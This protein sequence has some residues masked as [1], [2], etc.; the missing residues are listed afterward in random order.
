MRAALNHKASKGT[1]STRRRCRGLLA[2]LSGRE[3]RF[4]RHTN[5]CIAKT[6]VERAA[7]THAALA[8]ED[9]TGIRERT[10]QQRRLK[11]ERRR[12]NHW[13]FFQLRQFVT[14]KAALA[15]V[16]VYLVPAAYTSQMCH[17]CLYL[18]SRKGKR[19]TCTNHA[20]GWTGDADFNAAKNIRILGLNLVSQPRGPWVHCHL[21][22]S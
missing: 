20:C 19:F 13:A 5:H 14:Y 12:S 21:E 11:T 10:N 15:G 4:Q 7:E 9:L 17:G 3:H 6:L 16:V 18:G 2:R 1:R 8:L 22:G